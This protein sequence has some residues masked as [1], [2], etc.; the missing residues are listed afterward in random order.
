MSASFKN[1]TTTPLLSNHTFAGSSEDVGAYGSY[2]IAFRCSTSTQFKILQG[3]SINQWDDVRIL[4]E[5]ASLPPAFNTDSQPLIITGLLK[6]KYFKLEI[7]N[8][9]GVDQTYLRAD[10]VF[11]DAMPLNF[12]DNSIS[13]GGVDY[14]TGTRHLLSTTSTGLLKVES[15][16]TNQMTT[17]ATRGV[18]NLV[19]NTWYRVATVG[20]TAGHVWNSIGAIVSD[21]TVPQ[22]GRLFKCLYAPPSVVSG[23]GTCYDLEYTDTITETNS[24]SI[25]T[26]VESI[27]TKITA[28]NTG[29]V[30]VSSGNITETNSGSIKTAVESI[31]TKI[32]ACNT[33]AVVISSGSVSLLASADPTI[34]LGKV[35]ITDSY[36]AGISATAGNLMVGINNIY[37]ANPLNVNTSY[38]TSSITTHET[39]ASLISFDIITT[40]N[41]AQIKGSAGTLVSLTVYNDSASVNFIHLYNV[42]SA[43]VTVGTTTPIAVISLKKS[44]VS[45]VVLHSVNFSTAISFGLSSDYA[46]TA[47]PSGTGVYVSATYI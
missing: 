7:F 13:V 23:E 27:D 16:D 35:R 42:L 44:D 26:A 22:I 8:N 20:N 24:G 4:A 3:A 32:T 36:G 2:T 12:L 19:V 17:T 10:V 6:M 34:E 18:S 37:T 40:R 11:R 28:C 29:A 9:S 41:P 30:V 15:N 38:T 39:P 45:Q 31:N 1:S 14:A 47:S 43:S 33:G 25:K 46:G 21:E 5:P